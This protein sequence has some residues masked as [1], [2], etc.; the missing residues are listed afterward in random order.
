MLGFLIQGRS[1]NRILNST[2]VIIEEISLQASICYESSSGEHKLSARYKAWEFWPL[3]HMACLNFDCECFNG[4]LNL[5][6]YSNVFELNIGSELRCG[7]TFLQ[8]WNKSMKMSFQNAVDQVRYL[9]PHLNLDSVGLDH[10][11]V[12]KEGQLVEPH[13]A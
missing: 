13:S 12:V 11:K 6:R 1:R 4:V 10:R 8:K 5:L 9:F 3:E 2:R 7:G